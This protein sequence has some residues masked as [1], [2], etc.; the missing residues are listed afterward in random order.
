MDYKKLQAVATKLIKGFGNS[1]SA[2]IEYKNETSGKAKVSCV[3]VASADT[4]RNGTAVHNQSKTAYLMGTLKIA[5]ETNDVLIVGKK[6]FTITDVEDI[7]PDG[8]T[9]CAYKLQVS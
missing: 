8:I 9:T 7:T 1:Q 2:T 5:P 6:T 3:I 4:D